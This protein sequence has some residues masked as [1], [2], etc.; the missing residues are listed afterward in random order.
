[1]SAANLKIPVG[2]IK[3]P[4][5]LIKC[6]HASNICMQ[7]QTNDRKNAQKVGKCLQAAIEIDEVKC[8]K[9]L[10]KI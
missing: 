7:V 1:M 2:M 9:E 3:L 10:A 5:Y 6:I 8:I 4:H